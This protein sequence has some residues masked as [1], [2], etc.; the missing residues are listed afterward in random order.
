MK[1]ILQLFPFIGIVS[2]G[3]AI[4]LTELQQDP[5]YKGSILSYQVCKKDGT[6]ILE[7]NPDFLMIGASTWKILSGLFS[8]YYLGPKY[9]PQ[10]KFWID[11][12]NIWIDSPG[13]PS[14]TLD[15]VKLIKDQLNIIE[16]VERVYLKQAY[17]PGYNQQCEIEDISYS[18]SAS[19]TA[20]SLQGGTFKVEWKQG[21]LNP[22]SSQTGIT[23]KI[24]LKVKTINSSKENWT[25]NPFTKKIV[26]YEPN[27]TSRIL[28]LPYAKPDKSLARQLGKKIIKTSTTPSLGSDYILTGEKCINLLASALPNSNNWLTEQ[29]YFMA[30]N[31]INPAL[32]SMVPEDQTREAANKFKEFLSKEIN[33]SENE[34]S[35]VQASNGLTRHNLITV[36]ALN[37]ALL[38]NQKQSTGNLFQKCMAIPGK[39][40]TLKNRLSHIKGYFKTGSM[41]KVTALSGYI[42]T[43]NGEERVVSIILNHSLKSGIDSGKYIDQYLELFSQNH[44]C[45]K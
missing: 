24:D 43:A 45:E 35:F 10:T 28:T 21:K 16:P 1:N 11:N 19:V 40:G 15:K 5:N 41:D 27:F 18:Y 34:Y 39:E 14:I 22:V 32:S 8:L 3:V 44:I 38:W 25:Y 9:Q 4:S 33:L 31:K 17:N 36:K 13:D 30:V 29:L 42:I 2:N 26:F 7:K 6:V 37:K 20:W 23:P 12:K